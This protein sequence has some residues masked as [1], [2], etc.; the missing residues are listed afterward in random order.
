MAEH[1][2]QGVAK[3]ARVSAGSAR[4]HGTFGCTRMHQVALLPREDIEKEIN[5]LIHSQNCMRCVPPGQTGGVDKAGLIPPVEDWPG[6][7]I[8]PMPMK[9][10][11]RIAINEP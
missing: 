9:S 3:H 4:K 2:L 5:M 7:L 11:L 10:R 6:L 8:G 1:G